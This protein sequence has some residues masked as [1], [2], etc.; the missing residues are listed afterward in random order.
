M[1]VSDGDTAVAGCSRMGMLD[2]GSDTGQTKQHLG[3]LIEFL[4]A[5]HAASGR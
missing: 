5:K 2:A 3:K 4:A 1:V